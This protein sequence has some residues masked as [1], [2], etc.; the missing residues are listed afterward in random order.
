[1]AG[2]DPARLLAQGCHGPGARPWLVGLAWGRRWVTGDQQQLAAAIGNKQG[3]E[4][5]GPVQQVD[6][7]WQ[8]GGGLPDGARGRKAGE[9]I[10]LGL[11]EGRG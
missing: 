7:G 10:E 9:A 5:R 3:C 1:L 6:D 4:V 2:A 8:L 11:G